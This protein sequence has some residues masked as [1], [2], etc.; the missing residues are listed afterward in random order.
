[1]TEM[2]M[3]K[4]TTG[5]ESTSQET[6]TV[7]LMAALIIVDSEEHTGGSLIENDKQENALKLYAITVLKHYTYILQYN[8][9][10][11]CSSY[12][13]LLTKYKDLK[14]LISIPV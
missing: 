2:V 5:F 3:L 4:R 6:L 14:S 11:H 9:R 10:Q 12:Y 13:I 7:C 8:L 1:M